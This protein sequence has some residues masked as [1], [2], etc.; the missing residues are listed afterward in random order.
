MD[1]CAF[2]CTCDGKN[3][4]SVWADFR[5]N[6]PETRQGGWINAENRIIYPKICYKNKAVS[7]G[8]ILLCELG[9]FV[10]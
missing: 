2:I 8:R 1:G 3:C 9:A 7:I 5:E 6:S 4:A 10:V